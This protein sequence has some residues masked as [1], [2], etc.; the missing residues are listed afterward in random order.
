MGRVTNRLFVTPNSPTHLGAVNG[1]RCPFLQISRESA[2]QKLKKRTFYGNLSL[3]NG[4]R[5]NLPVPSRD[6]HFRRN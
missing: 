5:L 3:E 2:G 6:S 4:N 1:E